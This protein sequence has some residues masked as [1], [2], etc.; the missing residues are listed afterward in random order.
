MVSRPVERRSA[1][2]TA[3]DVKRA[4]SLASRRGCCLPRRGQPTAG[5]TRRIGASLHSACALPTD[6]ASVPSSAVLSM[7]RCLT[8]QPPVAWRRAVF[9][10]SAVAD[11]LGPRKD[12]RGCLLYTS[13][14]A[15]E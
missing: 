4:L 9:L 14:A 7:T 10:A 11:R 3:V 5:G 1:C 13:D 8:H 12:L 15:D 6:A 2:S